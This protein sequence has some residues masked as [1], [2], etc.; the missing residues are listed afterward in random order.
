[1]EKDEIGITRNADMGRSSYLHPLSEIIEK[2]RGARSVR[3][4]MG[5]FL[6]V[7]P[8]EFGRG[9]DLARSEALSQQRSEWIEFCNPCLD[10]RPKIFVTHLCL[11]PWRKLRK[12]QTQNFF[13]TAT[14]HAH[15]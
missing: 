11:G 15:F 3:I 14:F 7:P 1:F 10:R 9:R 5:H 8:H 12:D 4:K 13:F 6:N 2:R